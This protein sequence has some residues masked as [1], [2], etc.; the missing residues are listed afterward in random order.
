MPLSLPWGDPWTQKV[1]TE[2]E[3]V[4]KSKL[5]ATA[6]EQTADC[7]S[8]KAVTVTATASRI[9]SRSKAR[10]FRCEASLAQASPFPTLGCL[11]TTVRIRPPTVGPLPATQRGEC[12]A[13]LISVLFIPGY[14]LAR[15]VGPVALGQRVCVA[16][17]VELCV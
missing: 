4:P 8:A 6:V 16:M 12:G 17:V 9:R 2:R 15:G 1:S 3:D 11:S 10:S 5:A 14:I 13:C 7:D